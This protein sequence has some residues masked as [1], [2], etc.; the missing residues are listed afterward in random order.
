MRVYSLLTINNKI[1]LFMNIVY[2]ISNIV[3]IES[4]KNAG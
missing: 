1:D 3:N 2:E 4:K